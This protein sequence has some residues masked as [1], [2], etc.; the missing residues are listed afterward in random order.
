MSKI[1]AEVQP[2]DTSFSGMVE[3]ATRTLRIN[4]ADVIYIL[5][6][7]NKNPHVGRVLARYGLDGTMVKRLKAAL[8]RGSW[9]VL[10]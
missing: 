2:Q 10:V 7:Q 8:E 6:I 5:D 9:K 1:N 3:G 4:I